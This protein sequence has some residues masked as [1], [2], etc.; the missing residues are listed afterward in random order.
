[1]CQT[2]SAQIA[3]SPKHFA[4]G[5]TLIR[6]HIGMRH[7]MRFQVRTLI[8][9]ALADRTFVWRFFHVEYFMDG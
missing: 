2:V 7:L 4:T 9:T 5:R 8:E 3:V 6:F 1:M